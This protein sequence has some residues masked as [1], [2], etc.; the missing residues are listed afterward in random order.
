MPLRVEPIDGQA[1]TISDLA[2]NGILRDA[3]WL[4]REAAW[5]SP[6]PLVPSPLVS[7]HAQFIPVPDA[8]LPRRVLSLSTLKFTN[9][10]SQIE[11]LRFISG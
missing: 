6:A 8:R 10:C 1:L 3:S 11:A 4:L 5:V 9:L 7:K 2:L